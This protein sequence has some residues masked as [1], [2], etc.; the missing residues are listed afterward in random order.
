MSNGHRNNVNATATLTMLAVDANTNFEVYTIGAVAVSLKAEATDRLI[1]DGTAL[2][3][4]DKA[5]NLSTAG[6]ALSCR[7]DSAAGATVSSNG[8]SDDGA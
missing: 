6:D 2:D 5:T 3:D 7:Y 1:L 4:A 8:W